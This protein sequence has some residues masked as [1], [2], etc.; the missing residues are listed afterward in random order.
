[1]QAETRLWADLAKQAQDMA[2]VY[3]WPGQRVGEGVAE[4]EGKARRFATFLTRAVCL[5]CCIPTGVR[6][7]LSYNIDNTKHR[8]LLASPFLTRNRD[9]KHIEF[10]LRS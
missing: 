3:Q 2:A 10:P 4:D 5:F 8:P 6:T 7:L 9:T 1:M